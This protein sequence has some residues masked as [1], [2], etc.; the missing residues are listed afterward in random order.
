MRQEEASC[1]KIIHPPVHFSQFI[2]K[3][4]SKGNPPSSQHQSKQKKKRKVEINE[5]SHS[6]KDSSE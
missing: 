2:T 3:G 4:K 5:E 6:K 1:H